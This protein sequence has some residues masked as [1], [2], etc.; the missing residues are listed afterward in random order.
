M[1]D[2]SKVERS[3]APALPFMSPNVVE[4][5]QAQT[6]VLLDEQA[7]LLDETQKVTATWL[8]RRQEA[9][10]AGTRTFEATCGCKDPGTMAAIYS[11]WLTDNMNRVLADVNDAR[12]EGLRLAEIGQRSVGALFR[13]GAQIVSSTSKAVSAPVGRANSRARTDA[14][15]ATRERSAVA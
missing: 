4:T 8:K 7:D 11:E 3:L 9:M 1:S 6:R 13:Q 15:N 5:L 14:T 12:E 10:E 2:Q